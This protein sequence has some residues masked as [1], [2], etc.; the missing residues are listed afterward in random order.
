MSLNF[1]NIVCFPKSFWKNNFSVLNK[2]TIVFQPI[3]Q[4]ITI[5]ESFIIRIK[6]GEEWDHCILFILSFMWS[7][8]KQDTDNNIVDDPQPLIFGFKM[9]WEFWE[10]DLL[11]K[12]C[13]P[14]TNI[15]IVLFLKYISY[16]KGLWLRIMTKA[17]MIQWECFR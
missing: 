1:F 12:L 6:W 2:I 7:E 9:S 11:F 13:H 17:K 8:E 4:V 3:L 14:Y 10:I 5:G 15:N 16:T